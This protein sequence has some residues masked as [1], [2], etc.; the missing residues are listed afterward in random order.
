MKPVTAAA[1]FAALLICTPAHAQELTTKVYSA[2]LEP[3]L[4]ELEV[5]YGRLVGDEAD[6]EDGLLFELAHHFSK[7]FYGS[8]LLE[9]SRVPGEDRRIEG[10]GAEGIVTLGQIAGI[11]TALYGE[12]GINRRGA[13]DLEA[14]LLLEK[15]AG[16]LDARLNVIAEKELERGEPI[17]IGYAASVDQEVADDFR[18]GL[19]GVG[20]LGTTKHL[21]TQAEHF[22][23]PIAKYEVEHLPGRGEIELEAGYLFPL[24]EARGESNGLL[25]FQVEYG[26]RF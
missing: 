8:L 3:G 6:G 22:L 18:I 5:R 19:M 2:E 25:R 14:K 10:F 7:R 9:T 26:F 20:G 17:E 12:Y 21:T 11:Q 16:K 15:R 13:D 23:G 24:G 4:T 1:A